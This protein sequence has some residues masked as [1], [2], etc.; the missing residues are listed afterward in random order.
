MMATVVVR[1]IVVG[2]VPGAHGRHPH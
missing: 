1:V 2:L